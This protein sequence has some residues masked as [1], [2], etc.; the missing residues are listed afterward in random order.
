VTATVVIFLLGWA[1]GL[2]A[3]YANLRFAPRMVY[4]VASD[5]YS[6]LLTLSLHFHSRRPVGDSIRR[7]TTDCGCVATIVRDALLPLGVA[8]VTLFSMFA[9]MWRLDALLTLLALAVV[10]GMAFTLYRYAGPMLE[11]SYQ[12]QEVEGKIYDFVEHHLSAVPV[13]QAFGQEDEADRRFATTTG[14]ALGAALST[15]SVQLRFKIL[16]GLMIALGTAGILWV[17]GQHVLDG[18]LSVGSVLVFLSYLVSLYGPLETLM[19]TSSTIQGAAGS[20]RRVLEILESDPEVADRPGAAALPSAR[21]HVC[22][23]G[24]T[25]GYEPDRP[26]LRAVSL[27]VSPG[28]VVAIVGFTGAGKTTLVNLIARSFDPW[29]GRVLIDGRDVRDL[30][31]KDLR[32]QIAIVLQEPLLFPLSITDNIAYGRSGATRA[33]IELAARAASAHDFIHR[34]PHGYETVI[35]E[36][37]AT[38]SG[39]ERQRLSIARALL[40][41]A[42]I[43]LLDEPTSALDADTEGVLLGALQHLMK[44]RTTFIIAHRLS[45]IRHADWIL[46]MNQGRVAERGTHAELLARQGLYAHLHGVQFGL[47]PLIPAEERP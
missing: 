10:P 33:E 16:T 18:R 47:P 3:A 8:L 12:Q 11:R 39:G 1:L 13:V 31:L 40:K 41:D 45:T 4:D 35:G 36:R 38:L 17:G 44:G 19:Y 27:D 24:V 30:Q 32:R 9:I 23:E 25:F 26:V 43:L 21:G 28:Q 5:L 7:I 15:T 20:V 6:H 46:V 37:G 29:E 22:L 42:P 34:L 14:A 2:A